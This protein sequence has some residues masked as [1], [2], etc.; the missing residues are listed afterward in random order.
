MVLAVA[1]FS[2][3][4]GTAIAA[5]PINPLAGVPARNASNNECADCCSWGGSYCDYWRC[6]GGGTYCCPYST[7]Q[8]EYCDGICCNSGFYCSSGTCVAYKQ[9]PLWVLWILLAVGAI[10]LSIFGGCVFWCVRRS[11]LRQLR[12]YQ[13]MGPTTTTTLYTQAIPVQGAYAPPASSA[14]M[15]ATATP[16]PQPPAFAT[17][18]VTSTPGL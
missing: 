7:Y 3:L 10:A 6:C 14:Y 4:C 13:D 12:A 5:V 17:G 8:C 1:I 16:Y 9:A 15:S 2:L 11:R 18:A